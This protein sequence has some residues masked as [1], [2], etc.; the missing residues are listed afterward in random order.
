VGFCDLWVE[1]GVKSKEV[2]LG[3]YTTK[4]IG[5]EQKTDFI[6]VAGLTLPDKPILQLLQEKKFDHPHLLSTCKGIV[7]NEYKAQ[8]ASKNNSGFLTDL[9]KM[10]DN[11][12]KKLFLA[13]DWKFGEADEDELSK[14][15]IER[16]KKCKFFNHTLI[17]KE[18]IILSR[19]MD[20]IDEKQCLE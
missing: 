18:A 19:M 13:I 10:T 8:Y 11:D 15:L 3:F 7:L 2:Y 9:E 1:Y 14:S 16:I 20:V 17:G 12:W 5:Q 6:K 4:G